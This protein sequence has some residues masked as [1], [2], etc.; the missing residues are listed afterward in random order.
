M[1][2]LNKKQE[3]KKPVKQQAQSNKNTSFTTNVSNQNGYYYNSVPSIAEDIVVDTISDF[4]D[5]DNNSQD[6]DASSDV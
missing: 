2:V 6:Y 3:Q 1:S 4:F 5:N